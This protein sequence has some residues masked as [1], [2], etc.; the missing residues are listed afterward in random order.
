MYKTTTNLKAYLDQRNSWE[1]LFRQPALEIGRDNQR[2]ADMISSD[3][4]PENLCMDGEASASY[5]RSR[6]AQLT[7]AARELQQ[8][9]PTVTFYETV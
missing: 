2:I 9:D 8:L 1:A 4:S 5:I 3:L 6:R 7:A